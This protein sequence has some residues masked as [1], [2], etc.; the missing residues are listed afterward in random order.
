MADTN[1]KA[2]AAPIWD[3]NAARDDMSRVFNDVPNS[4]R[5][6]LELTWYRNIL[7]YLGE[8]WLDW[9]MSTSS[10]GRRYPLSIDVPTPV[11]NIIRDFVRT[12]K[13]LVLNK[14][15]TA[16]VWPNSNEQSDKDAAKL[17]EILLR[18]MDSADNDS[19]EDI[20]EL[21]AMW[22]VMTGNGFC[23]TLAGTDNGRYIVGKKSGAIVAN[24]GDVI[25]EH[26][27]PFSVVVPLMGELINQ[28][29]FIGIKS[30]K[31]REWVQDTHEVL[32]SSGQ[33]GDTLEVVYQR[34]L[35]ELVA[36]VSPWK[37]RALESSGPLND[38]EDL[39]DLVVYKELEYRPTR[40]YPQGRHSVLCCGQLCARNET[41]PVPVGDDGT[42][43][44][45]L[46]HFPY[47]YTPGGFW[48]CGGVDD[49]VS[50]Q[51]I[52]NE[53]DQDLQTNRKSLG[54]PM[55]LTPKDLVLKRRSSAGSKLLQ[56]QWDPQ[57]SHGAKPEIQPGVP[58]PSQVLEER[59]IHRVTAQEASGDPKNILR[60]QSPHSGASGIMVDIL[61]ERAEQSHTPD[62]MR[63]YRNWSRMSRKRLVL[64]QGLY[65]EQRYAKVQGE[66]NAIYVK[67][68]LGADLSNNNDVRLELDSGISTTHAGRTQ[69]LLKLIELGFFGEAAKHPEIQREL[70]KR[71]GLSGFPDELNIHKERAEWEN[72]VMLEGNKKEVKGIAVANVPVVNP[73]T[74][75]EMIGKD[76]QPAMMFTG[77]V[78]PLFELDP[79][80]IHMATHDRVLFGREF[81]E[82]PE[83]QQLLMIAHRMAHAD[84]LEAKQREMEERMAE[85]QGKGK[86][87]GA[88][89]EGGAGGA[90]GAGGG[91]PT[92][93][94]ED[95]AGPG[96]MSDTGLDGED[97][98][99]PEVAGGEG[100][101]MVG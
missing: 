70:M 92:E 54:R 64:A 40:S 81:K 85:L 72:S 97:F 1:T 45:S 77:H 18:D 19:L 23:R 90:G 42:W 27:I 89:G 68:F 25:V 3:D 95:L 17:G 98:D 91:Q 32:L 71:F 67:S 14:R 5:V 96:G 57:L 2:V 50:P 39:E 47:N 51:N 44:Y 74:G 48:A 94:L 15:Y 34:E 62:V 59:A 84:K 30:L 31:T 6:M 29:S 79:D 36:N 55:V 26:I 86:D 99:T 7:Y 53:V 13:A 78:D 63:F 66:G 83:E 80:E 58:Y 75:Q 4:T 88:G 9:Y 35:M 101:M 49:L 38:D 28:K 52:I 76:G 73:E 37:G 65:T 93:N 33:T 82:L 22:M 8:Q 100:D 69:A 56:V 46:T 41:M 16:R 12:M 87:Q 20:K 11:S 10:F 60:G 24:Q 43:F 21:V 61:S